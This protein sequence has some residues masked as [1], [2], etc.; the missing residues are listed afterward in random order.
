MCVQGARANAH[1]FRA[2]AYSLRQCGAVVR[3]SDDHGIVDMEEFTDGLESDVRFLTALADSYDKQRRGA[4]WQVWHP[5]EVLSE[6]C[7]TNSDNDRA[8]V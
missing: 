6:S 1:I 4:I 3:G 7:L 8:G 5:D 2:L